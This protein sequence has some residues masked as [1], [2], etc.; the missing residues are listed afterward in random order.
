M[1]SNLISAAQYLRMSTDQQQYS[2]LNQ[3]SAIAKYARR[4]NFVVVK[5]YEDAG[6]GG[7]A[8]RERPGL[9][10][11]LKDVVAR[12]LPYKA[13]LVYDVSRW[14]RFN[15]DGVILV[16][17]DTAVEHFLL[18]GLGIEIPCAVPVLDD[19]NRH[20]PVFCPNVESYALVGLDNHAMHLIVA[21][22]E[23][24]MP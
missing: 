20:G 5:T 10:S 7:L 6:R 8:L 14:G 1:Q 23:P 17:V 15:I 16:G 9:Q 3:A 12:D 4:N 24:T 19:G 11:L 2:L 13:I 18:A 21:A 22:D